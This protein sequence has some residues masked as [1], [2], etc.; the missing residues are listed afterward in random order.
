MSPTCAQDYRQV[1]RIRIEHGVG[2][3]GSHHGVNLAT[4]VLWTSDDTVVASSFG[5]Y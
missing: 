5:T 4:F 2:Y 1:S 3:D